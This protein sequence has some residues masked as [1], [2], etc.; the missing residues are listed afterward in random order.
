VGSDDIFRYVWDG[1]VSEA[2]IN[3]FAYAPTDDRLAHLRTDDLPA[4]VNFPG[5]R[6]IYPPLAQLF[7]EFSQMLFG[8]SVR[9]MKLLLALV[10]VGS[11]CLLLW[12][13]ICHET[14]DGPAFT[15]MPIA[16]SIYAWSPIPVMYIALDGH[17]DAL[18]IPFM[19][20]FIGLAAK[21]RRLAS[22]LAL[23]LSVLAKLYP[24]LILPILTKLYGW[25]KGLMMAGVPLIIVAGGYAMYL[26]PTGGVFEA[27]LI[28][29]RIFEFNGSV[30]TLLTSVMGDRLTSRAVCGL[31]F[32]AWAVV[33]YIRYR[34]LPETALLLFLGFLLFSPT[35]HPWYFIWLAAL[36]PIR[37]S[38]SIYVLLGLTN[39]SN[40]VVYYYRLTGVWE[41]SALGVAVEYLPFV[42][43][44][45]WEIVRGDWLGGIRS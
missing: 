13:L 4:L 16:L 42:F 1:K 15:S 29:N 25:R 12:F 11:I 2:G 18:G 37:W 21:G 39:I 23:G 43:L 45:T 5:M 6:T 33:L 44:F 40:I 28:Y 27:I 36:L 20:M 24:L 35:A 3:P 19:L 34:S 17:I 22:S 8:D 9:G 7:F 10:D 26:E 31:L 41:D 32:L 38:L 14:E 30:Y